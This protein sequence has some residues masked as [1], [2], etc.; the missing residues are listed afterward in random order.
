MP[1]PTCIFKRLLQ[2]LSFLLLWAWA[3][4]PALAQD[5]ITHRAWLEDPTGQLTWPQVV[6]EPTQPFEGVLSRGF[7]KAVVWVQLRID[8]GAHPRPK[9]PTDQLILRIRPVYLDDIQVFAPL[10]PQGRAGTTGDV[11]HPRSQPMEGL[12]FLLPIARG[13]APRDIWLRLSSTSTRQIAVQALHTDDMQRLSQIQD[14]VFALYIGVIL[15]FVVWGMVYWLFSR[16]LVIGAFG[17]KQATALVF[18]LCSLGYLRV[19]WPEDWNA[20]WLDEITTLSGIVAVSAAVYFHVVLL[21][22]FGPPLWVVRIHHAILAML[23]LKLV[24]LC[25]CQQVMLVL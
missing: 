18:A 10:A 17:L 6:S 3:L 25:V 8:P 11:H 12:D 2:S 23:P 5:H 4:Q 14:L 19:F 7:G 22:E 1:C 13:D 20:H 21:R 24:L 9:R 16:E 15:V